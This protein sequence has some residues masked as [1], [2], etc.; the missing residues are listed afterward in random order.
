MHLV[1]K[2][3]NGT[4]ITIHVNIHTTIYDVK[5]IISEKIH[6]NIE[7]ILIINN[8]NKK[9]F[10]CNICRTKF[11]INRTNHFIFESI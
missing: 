5:K 6:H 11:K 3:L 2:L 9:N 7:D 10:C 8:V 1:F 4:S